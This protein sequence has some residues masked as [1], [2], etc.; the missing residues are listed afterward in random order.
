[1]F[2]ERIYKDECKAQVNLA[3]ARSPVGIQ[4]SP[5]VAANHR[6]LV[7]QR[8]ERRAAN[9]E[10]RERMRNKDEGELSKTG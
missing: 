8:L 4:R 7:D 5:S 6:D 10:H 1:M 9:K 3:A 2:R